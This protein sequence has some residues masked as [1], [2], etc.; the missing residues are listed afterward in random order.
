MNSNNNPEIEN[1]TIST[2]NVNK[3]LSSNDKRTA[4][5]KLFT[6]THCLLMQETRGW[7]M[8]K[9]YLK[10]F[11]RKG[12]FSSINQSAKGSAALIKND[13]Q[14][15]NEYKDTNGRIAFITTTINNHIFAIGSVYMPNVNNS[16]QAKTE[17]SSTLSSLDKI[18]Q[19]IKTKEKVKYWVL[20]GDWNLIISALIDS[21]H[22][23]TKIH[24]DLIIDLYEILLK[25]DITDAY[26]HKHPD[27]P[28]YSYAPLG[29]NQTGTFRLLDRIYISNELAAN[30]SHI[31]IENCHLS[32]H[33]SV[34][35]KLQFSTPTKGNG[36]WRHNDT[37]LKNKIYE[38]GMKDFIRASI[39]EYTLSTDQPFGS[40]LKK[41]EYINYKLGDN[42]R[43]MQTVIKE[44]TLATQRNLECKLKILDHTDPNNASEIGEAKTILDKFMRQQDE[45]TMLKARVKK[46]QNDEKCTSF[47]FNRIKQ[48]YQ[49]TNISKLMIDSHTITNINQINEH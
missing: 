31:T 11:N 18:M 45:E 19:Q 34:N 47:F 29:S 37:L 3:G 42:A 46:A 28:N 35:L 40:K 5:K 13:F 6:N 10:H 9:K 1:L 24:D 23:N 4:I 2:I 41:W 39:D 25:Y 14:L 44:A 38:E 12:V 36:I 7:Q 30:I 33:R 8:E 20:G 48:N 17:W 27:T 32:D 26:R 21:E 49:N 22:P 16:E 43:R 15:N